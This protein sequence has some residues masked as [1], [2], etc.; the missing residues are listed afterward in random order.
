VT[1]D[2]YVVAYCSATDT[3]APSIIRHFSTHYD[4]PVCD[5]ITNLTVSNIGQTSATLEWTSDGTLWEVEFN[6]T[7]IS[8]PDN[9]CTLSGLTVGTDYSVRVRNVCDASADFYSE[10]SAAVSFRTDTIPV[11]PQGIDDVNGTAAVALYPNPASTT[12]TIAVRGISGTATVTLVDL[13]GRTCGSWKAEDGQLVVV[14]G[15]MARGAY[16][17][18]VTGENTS[19]VRKLVLR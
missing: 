11:E 13:N 16:V 17:V 6:G 9:P 8:T 7:V 15:G 12:V 1:Y 3:S 10:W 14:L 18:R 2:F 4:A 19:V 5:T